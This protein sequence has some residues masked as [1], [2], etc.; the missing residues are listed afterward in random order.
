MQAL[1]LAAG[2]G[3]RL[4][5]NIPKPLI[6]INGKPLLIRLIEQLKGEGIEQ[7]VVVTGH[8]KHLIEGAIATY[9]VN[10]IFNPFYPISDNLASF[11]IGRHLISDTC[12]MSHGDLIFVDELLKKLIEADGDVVLPMDSSSLDNESMKMKVV[13]GKLIDLSKSIPLNGTTGE[14]IPLMKFSN[15][16]LPELKNLMENILE[17]G[18]FRQFVE[19]AVLKLI[20]SGNFNTTVLDVTGLQWAEI[21]IQSDLENALTLFNK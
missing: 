1:I 11:W 10:T 4:G 21:D 13:D 6:E 12:I 9:G 2:A 17:T 19:A 8:Q 14:S 5:G 3:T 7:I 18:Q 15:R 16:A 20:K